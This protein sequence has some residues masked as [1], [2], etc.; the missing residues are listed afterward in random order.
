MLLKKIPRQSP[1]FFCCSSYAQKV[2]L[3]VLR[4]IRHRTQK[5]VTRNHQRHLYIARAS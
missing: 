3:N 5:N 1:V 2:E 4:G